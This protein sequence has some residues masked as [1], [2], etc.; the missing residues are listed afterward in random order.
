PTMWRNY[1]TVGLR[2]LA[3]NK[4]YAVINILGLA[5]GLAA[6]FALFVYVR[7]ETSY[8]RWLPD[9]ERIFQ[10][11]ATWHEVGQPVS[12]S[13]SSPAPVRDTIASISPQVEAVSVAIPARTVVT[14]DGQAIYL[15]T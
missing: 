1:L 2:N 6:C 15:E 13:Q 3:R 12:P 7:Y 9:S 8:D 5:I 11:Q 14:R 10:V 4:T